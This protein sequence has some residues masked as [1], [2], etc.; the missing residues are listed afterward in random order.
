MESKNTPTLPSLTNEEKE[1]FIL[2]IQSLKVDDLII[3]DEQANVGS[4]RKWYKFGAYDSM[5]ALTEKVVKGKG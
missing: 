1:K 2:Y 5:R 4:K 3:P